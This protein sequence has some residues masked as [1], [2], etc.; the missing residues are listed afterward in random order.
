[1]KLLVRCDALDKTY[2]SRTKR[3]KDGREIMDGDGT[4]AQERLESF[5]AHFYVVDAADNQPFFIGRPEGYISL[6]GLTADAAASLSYGNDYHVDLATGTI[7]AAGS[8]APAAPPPATPA[9]TAPAPDLA[10]HA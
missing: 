8:A 3:D 4:P 10:P 5:T 6:P 2:F 1:M 9:A 7:T